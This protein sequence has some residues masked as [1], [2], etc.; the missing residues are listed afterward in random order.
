MM[1]MCNI[2][3]NVILAEPLK[4]KSESEQL[5][6]TKKIQECFKERGF[7]VKVLIL[8]NECPQAIK[9]N[10]REQKI[11]LKLVPPYF[12]RTNEAEVAIKIFKNHLL[13]DYAVLIQIFPCICG[14]G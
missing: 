6:A 8:D 13:L 1:V 10:L 2:D 12:H 9:K 3:P 11:N 4:K 5:R 14:V 7:P